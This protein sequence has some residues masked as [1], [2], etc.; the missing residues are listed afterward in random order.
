MIALVRPLMPAASPPHGAGRTIGAMSTTTPV[1]ALDHPAA[2]DVARVGRKAADLAAARAAGLPVA[3]GVVLTTEW[4][5]DDRAT[6]AQVWRITS[7]DGMRPLVVQS[8]AVTTDP[9]RPAD[10][11]AIE[12]VTVVDDLDAMLAA[13]GAL[14]ADDDT[15]PVLLQPHVPSAWRGVLFADADA[16][17]RSA[18][19]IAVAR[20]DAH[21]LDWVAELDAQRPGARRHVRRTRRWPAGRRA[22]PPDSAG[23]RCHGDVRPQ[24][25]SGVGRRRRRAAAAAAGPPA[26][27]TC[28]RRPWVRRDRARHGPARRRRA[29]HRPPAF[30]G[31]RALDDSAA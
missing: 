9:R 17:G 1:I 25:R 16:R 26:S 5:T 31:I 12:S 20:R 10:H 27:C 23:R 30:V 6:A 13:A 22:E 8:S 2:L 4:S 29:T 3:P 11:G 14:R 28:A 21:A 19:S 24:P 7:H 15:T 18:T